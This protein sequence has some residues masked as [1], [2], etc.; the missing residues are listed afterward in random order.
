MS[1]II[2]VTFTTIFI[3]S[4]TFTFHILI[5][6]HGWGLEIKNIWAI[7]LLMLA[8]VLIVSWSSWITSKIRN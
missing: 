1:S 8:Q 4:I 5:M 3:F 6:A 7:A 2:Y